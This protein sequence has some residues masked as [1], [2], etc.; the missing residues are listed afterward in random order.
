MSDN[1]Y[2]EQHWDW[3]RGLIKKAETP[4]APVAHKPES[5][6]TTSTADYGDNVYAVHTT[7]DGFATYTPIKG[8]WR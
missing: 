3:I 2:D 1:D 5:A 7:S 6:P 8:M 4:T